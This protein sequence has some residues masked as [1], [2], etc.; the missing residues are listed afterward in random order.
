M[1]DSVIRRIAKV[2]LSVNEFSADDITN[3]GDWAL[4]PAHGAN[5]RQSAISTT[6]QGL[7]K[8]GNIVWTGEVVK[9]RSPHRRGGIIRVWRLTTKGRAWAKDLLGR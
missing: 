4:D 7:S 5:G 6:F 9:S 8:Q 2:G 3:D 1:N